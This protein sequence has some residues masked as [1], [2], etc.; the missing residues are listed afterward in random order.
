M[1][2]GKERKGEKKEKRGNVKKKEVED[3]KNKK[4]RRRDK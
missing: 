4:I 3:D 1:K 2:K